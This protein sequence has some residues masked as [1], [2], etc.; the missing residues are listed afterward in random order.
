MMSANAPVT[1]GSDMI[2]KEVQGEGMLK[3]MIKGMLKGVT[4]KPQM[5]FT[6]N[7]NGC[8]WAQSGFANQDT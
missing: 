3:D 4:K 6:Q 2:R 7:Q 8:V 5:K 1:Q